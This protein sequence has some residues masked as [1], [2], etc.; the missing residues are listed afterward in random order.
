MNVFDKQ[1]L[2]SREMDEERSQ[3]SKHN[4]EKGRVEGHALSDTWTHYRPT[5]S[6]SV[7]CCFYTPGTKYSLMYSCTR[8]DA[9]D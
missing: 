5:V 7:W 3:S 9:A 8:G 6:N 1:I 4:S 2:K